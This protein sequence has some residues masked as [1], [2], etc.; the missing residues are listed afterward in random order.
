[1]DSCRLRAADARPR[2]SRRCGLSG[3]VLFRIDSAGYFWCES[4]PDASEPRAID[5]ACRRCRRRREARRHGRGG[6]RPSLGRARASGEPASEAVPARP[7]RTRAQTA[8]RGRRPLGQH[9]ARSRWRHQLRRA[10]GTPR[11]ERGGAAFHSPAR[12][13]CRVTLSSPGS[14]LAPRRRR[15]FCGISPGGACQ[16]AGRDARRHG[17]VRLGRSHA[18]GAR[19]KRVRGRVPLLQSA[20]VNSACPPL[21]GPAKAR[22]SPRPGGG[23]PSPAASMSPTAWHTR[24]LPLPSV[25]HIRVGVMLGLRNAEYLDTGAAP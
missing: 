22:P 3:A 1:M 7:V 24:G 12:A 6:R 23:R 4:T 8:P 15:P 16:L 11:V 19:R 20:D 25:Q 2:R 10:P 14:S 21:P 18:R 13:A 9:T 5:R 17:A